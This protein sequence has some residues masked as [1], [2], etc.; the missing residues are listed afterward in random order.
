MSGIFIV[1]AKRTPFG[2]FGGGLKT[3]TATDLGTAA[4]KAA[5]QQAGANL[6]PALID[7]VYFGNVIQS[8]SDA[9]YLARHV[10][11]QSGLNISTP[12]LTI[13]RLCGSGFETVILG[14]KDIQLGESQIV[15]CGGSE[16]MSQAPLNVNG[17]DA[18]WGVAL[19]SGLKLD[20]ALWNGLTDSYCNTP[21]GMTAEN[22]AEKYGIGRQECDE[23]AIRSQT[24][25]GAAK[26]SGVFDLEM[27][28]VEITTKKG[29]TV[30]S[31]IVVLLCVC[32]ASSIL[33]RFNIS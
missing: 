30:S 33:S 6:D 24:T 4:T 8:S 10:G 13:N 5:L 28:P 9:A 23:F 7:A 19:G 29:T 16:N 21:M 31:T 2:A 15:V 17:I 18:R 11:L 27:A 12:A 14:S 22:L 20:D 32:N 1:A 3:L 25:W 26:S